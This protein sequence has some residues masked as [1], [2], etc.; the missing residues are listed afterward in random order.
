MLRRAI[1]L[2]LVA[3]TACDRDPPP[4]IPIL[5]GSIPGVDA[6]PMMI[7]RDSGPAVPVIDGTI[8]EREWAAAEVEESEVESDREGSVLS[9]LH[10]MLI[11]GRLF[12][13]V[14]GT[15]ASGDAIVLYVD[16][17]LGEGEGVLPHEL[18][19]RDGT[20]DAALTQPSLTVPAG[21]EIDFAWGTT[22]MPHHG[23]GRDEAIGWRDVARNPAAFTVLDTGDAP[24]ACGA[25]VCETSISLDALGGTRPR[26]IALFAR[27]VRS[28]GGLTNQ[29]LPE[30]DG[31]RPNAVRA[32]LRI[33]DRAEPDAGM[34][35]AGVPRDGGRPG[36]G[37]VVDGV[38]GAAEW[39]AATV[40]R[41]EISA[42][43]PFAGNALSTLRALRDETHLHVAIEATL[44]SGNALLMYVD[45]DLGGTD[46]LV[47]PTLL[48]DTLGELDRALAKEIF[49]TADMRIDVAWGTTRMPFATPGDAMGWRDISTD[50]S[51]FRMV[52][53]ASACS[54]TACETSI[55]LS[56]LGAGASDDIALF[57]R[58]GSAQTIAMSNQMLPVDDPSAPEFASTFAILRGR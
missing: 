12:V 22:L 55:P 16:R 53:A 18:R 43:G 28:D 9:A 32:L 13:A 37:I 17:D 27:I 40:L 11:G 47:S 4:P 6:G 24:S 7:R 35:D 34:P 54:S 44:T 46:G 8:A 23:V 58:L 10:A 1:V 26:T 14:E 38:I 41:N 30:D 31:S 29:T 56:A 3:C 45:R 48:S 49:T 21:F 42:V 5:D 2:F 20:L 36:V 52:S 50:P 19:D 15:V 25:T 33:E 51:A 39:S 57:V